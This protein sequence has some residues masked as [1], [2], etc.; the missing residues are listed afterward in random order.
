MLAPRSEELRAALKGDAL[1]V[2]PPRCTTKSDDKEHQWTLASCNEALDKC[3][4]QAA[5]V[6]AFCQQLHSNS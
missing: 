3:S 6:K 4:T 2:P 1:N 5:L